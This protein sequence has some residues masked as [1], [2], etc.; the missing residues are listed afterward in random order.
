MRQSKRLVPSLSKNL[1]V[2]LTDFCAMR[3]LHPMF[4]PL[5]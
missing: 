2:E 1:D 5:D 3:L 4:C